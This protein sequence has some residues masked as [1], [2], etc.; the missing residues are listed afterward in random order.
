M[1]FHVSKLTLRL[2]KPISFSLRAVS[3]TKH[4]NINLKFT[5]LACALSRRSLHSVVRQASENWSA[6]SRLL[7]SKPSKYSWAVSTAKRLG[8]FSAASKSFSLQSAST[9]NRKSWFR[10]YKTALSVLGLSTGAIAALHTSALLTM[11]AETVNLDSDRTD[12][13][14]AKS[15]LLSAS[16]EKRREFY[17]VDHLPLEKIPVWTS[18]GTSADQPR[19]KIS[20][21]LSQKISLFR[22]D[23]TKLEIDAIVNAGKIGTFKMIVEFGN[24][25]YIPSLANFDKLI[26]WIVCQ[27]HFLLFAAG[28]NFF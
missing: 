19:H 6:N 28:C 4:P 9:P 2:P 23:I 21:A 18:T 11:S 17:R 16:Q 12:W 22:G 14:E 13:Q 20:D 7:N 1:A 3:G 27:Q 10:S 8:N 15:L 5:D 24:I 25:C 26:Q